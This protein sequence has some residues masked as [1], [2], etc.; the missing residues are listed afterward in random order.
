MLEVYLDASGK[1]ESSISSVAGYLATTE[2][3][4]KVM[5]DWA[6]VLERHGLA[7]FHG[8]KVRRNQEL[9]EGL[10]AVIERG[11]LF[12]IGAALVDDHW[13]Q[14]N[15]GNIDT[16]KRRNPYEQCLALALEN[17][18]RF[19]RD[20]FANDKVRIFCCLDARERRIKKVFDEVQRDHHNLSKIAA[21][22]SEKYK[23]IELADFGARQLRESWF[24]IGYEGSENPWGAMPMGKGRRQSQSFWSLNP[25]AILFHSSA[26][27]GRLAPQG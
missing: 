27:T 9:I 6:V 22:T 17:V 18:S 4:A 23:E 14:D 13:Q 1:G 20:E 10:R 25:N 8:K 12:A 24:K 15:W 5:R 7:A 26:S 16:E 19:V 11:Q 3:W 2:E 21:G